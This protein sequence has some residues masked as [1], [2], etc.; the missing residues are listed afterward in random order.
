MIIGDKIVH[1]A[2]F[3]FFFLLLIPLLSL[4]LLFFLSFWKFY[5]ILLFD[6]MIN[7]HYYAL[8]FELESK[9]IKNA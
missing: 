4:C 2:I 7:E 1:A 5:L 8:I 9:E 6:F 3:L